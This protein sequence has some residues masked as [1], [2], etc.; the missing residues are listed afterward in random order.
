[1]KTN[2]LSS[3]YTIQMVRKQEGEFL[4]KQEQVQNKLRFMNLPKGSLIESN[5]T[6]SNFSTNIFSSLVQIKFITKIRHLA[7]LIME[8]AMN[9]TLKLSFGRRPQNN[10]NVFLHIFQYLG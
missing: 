1:V 4:D 5:A 6:Y 3:N 8:I 10:S 2:S 9:K 7:S